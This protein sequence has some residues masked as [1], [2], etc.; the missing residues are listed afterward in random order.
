MMNNVFKSFSF[1]HLLCLVGQM[2][3]FTICS[4]LVP[5]FL[6]LIAF[7]TFKIQVHKS[8]L[9]NDLFH[10]PLVHECHFYHLGR[11]HLILNKSM[12]IT[13]WHHK[14][15]F[16]YWKLTQLS[17][18]HKS[19]DCISKFEDYRHTLMILCWSQLSDYAIKIH[20]IKKIQQYKIY[21]NILTF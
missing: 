9:S 2:S 15:Y 18:N 21:F 20:Q 14:N 3:H 10:N 17:Y 11:S 8:V 12:I 16:T 5:T 19:Y 6:N 13:P 7:F 1:T 4:L